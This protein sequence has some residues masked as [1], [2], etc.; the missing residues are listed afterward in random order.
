MHKVFQGVVHGR[1]IEL[2]EDP[3]VGDGQIVHVVLSTPP[4]A[5][6]WGE[7]LRRCAGALAD[8]WTDEDDRVLDQLHEERRRDARGE[9]PE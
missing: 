6:A 7:G 2:A 8:Q 1:T 3:G 5:E 9:S 4:A